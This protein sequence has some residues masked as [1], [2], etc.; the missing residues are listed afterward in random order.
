MSKNGFFATIKGDGVEA[1]YRVAGTQITK[2]TKNALLK[3]LKSKGINNKHLNSV[4]NFLDTEMGGAVLSTLV[5]M[6]LDH[7]PA[8]KNDQR[9]RTMS[10]EFRVSGMALVGNLMADAVLG[11]LLSSLGSIVE[12]LPTPPTKIRISPS[13]M[14]RVA[15]EKEEETEAASK[16]AALRKLVKGH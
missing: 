3:L 5:G 9:A 15:E 2:A 7:I 4:S 13:L 6:I 14:T 10:K 11:D 1:A 8:L 12:Q 16:I